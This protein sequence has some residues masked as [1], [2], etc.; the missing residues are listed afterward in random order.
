MLL[1]AVGILIHIDIV[2]CVSSDVKLAEN[3]RLSPDCLKTTSKSTKR[4]PNSSTTTE[5][6][7]LY[8]IPSYLILVYL[9]LYH[10][11]ILRPKNVVSKQIF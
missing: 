10:P 9:K 11:Y 6:S 7:T 1:R 2:S 3:E 5:T 8:Y 4:R